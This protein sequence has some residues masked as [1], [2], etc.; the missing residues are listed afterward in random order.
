MMMIIIIIKLQLLNDFTLFH[1]DQI[2]LVCV[3]MYFQVI[4]EAYESACFV[5]KARMSVVVYT[6]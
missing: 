4:N 3:Y 5:S 2:G 1:T 6:F